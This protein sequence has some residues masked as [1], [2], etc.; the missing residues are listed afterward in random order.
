MGE[1][2]AMQKFTT[3]NENMNK[4]WKILTKSKPE[5][6]LTEAVIKTAE[7]KTDFHEWTKTQMNNAEAIVKF[8][9]S[10]HPG[11]D[12]GEALT[13]LAKDENLTVIYIAHYVIMKA[14]IRFS[15]KIPDKI[16]KEIT[17]SDVLR[18]RVLYHSILA[19]ETHT[20]VPDITVN[21]MMSASSPWPALHTLTN[22]VDRMQRDS[23]RRA[24]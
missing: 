9:L 24:I 7:G 17:D 3:F 19:H 5:L 20:A 8:A 13:A 10:K 6:P 22:V 11:A 16:D 12:D 21:R 1:T 14:L 4:V 18:S 23:Q 2:E 15:K